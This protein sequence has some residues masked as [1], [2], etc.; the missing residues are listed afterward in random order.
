MSA[1][2]FITGTDTDVGKTWATVSLMHYVKQQGKTVL[3]MKPVA[4]G[5]TWRHGQ[6]HNAD[7]LLL[8]QHSSCQVAYE[9][10]NPYVYEQAVSPHIAGKQHPVELNVVFDCF[11]KLQAQADVV[12][13]EG[14][15]G[16]YSPINNQQDNSD[17]AKK[18]A[19]PVII[20]VAIRLGC[21]NH[22]KLSFQAVAQSGLLCAGWLAQC[23][24]ATMLNR[25]EN[26]HTI[27]AALPIPLLG[28]MP[29]TPQAD[30]AFFAEQ[31]DKAALDLGTFTP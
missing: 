15:G 24:D 25:E 2:Y 4:A 12:L 20:V 19:L 16:W 5:A 18:L 28:V 10:I 23:V 3:G 30:F 7:A 17:L 26:I 8:Q 1:G 29:Y 13:V 21:I 27:T 22:A 31:I 11:K 14:A 9:L 6:L